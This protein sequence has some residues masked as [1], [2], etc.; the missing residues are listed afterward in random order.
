MIEKIDDFI[1]LMFIS[2]T[3]KVAAVREIIESKPAKKLPKK[4]INRK[5]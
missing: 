3:H 1:E 2:S 5:M 4:G